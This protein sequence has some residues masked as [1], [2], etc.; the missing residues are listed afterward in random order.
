MRALVVYESMYG[1]THAVADHVAAG[2]R[3]TFEATVVPVTGA[4]AD[5][6]G[7]VGLRCA[8]AVRQRL[9]R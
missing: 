5:L 4:T 7:T 3:P 9:G 1:N 6:V 2:L 8:R